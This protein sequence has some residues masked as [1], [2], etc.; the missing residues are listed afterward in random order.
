MELNNSDAGLLILEDFDYV[1]YDLINEDLNIFCDTNLEW[2][3]VPIIFSSPERSF[4]S[5][6][7]NHLRDDNGTLIFPIIS[8]SRSTIKKLK[9]RSSKYGFNIPDTP[10]FKKNSF[11]IHSEVNTEKTNL[12][13]RLSNLKKKGQLNFPQ[14]PDKVVHNMYYSKQPSTLEVVYS[15]SI[16]CNFVSQM[17]QILSTFLTRTNNINY[18]SKFRNNN[19]FEIFLN[20]DNNISNSTKELEEEERFTE[21]EF[22]I[23]IRGHIVGADDN[24]NVPSLVIRESAVDLSFGVEFSGDTVEKQYR[25]F[26]IP[27]FENR[28]NLLSID[29]VLLSQIV[30]DGRNGYIISGVFDYVNNIKRGNLVHID[31]Y[32]NVTDL[33]FN[34]KP[35]GALPRVIRSGDYIYFSKI[36][37]TNFLDFAT[38]T[39]CR[40]NISD[41]KLDQSFLPLTNGLVL[42][43]KE[44]DNFL[45]IS[46]QFTSAFSTASP[47]FFRVNKD[48]L[49]I[50][51][52]F[53]PNASSGIDD[54]VFRDS[55]IIVCG[56]FGN[57][58]SVVRR[59]IGMISKI[60][61]SLMPWDPSIEAGS[62]SAFKLYLTEDDKLYVCGKFSTVNNSGISKIRKGIARFNFNDDVNNEDNWD[63]GLDDASG[64]VLVNRFLIQKKYIYI[65]GNYNLY[66]SEPVNGLIRCS[67][68]SSLSKDSYDNGF[69]PTIN[70][71]DTKIRVQNYY[72]NGIS[73][74]ALGSFNHNG[75]IAITSLRK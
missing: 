21:V 26:I 4:L 53:T 32:G 60:D 42:Q 6:E 54:F 29:Y 59:R 64:I 22:D 38:S 61:G 65:F 74:F 63:A 73:L 1:M 8:I 58:H 62:T 2:S 68:E 27:K 11:L 72:D 45:Y 57:L 37:M 66:Q 23:L 52:S 40:I 18:I 12:R 36:G 70:S 33:D 47:Y 56:P 35:L 10:D 41:F 31:K 51:N 14:K 16:K 50:D 19:K 24:N 25:K 9:A 13:T 39:L 67:T 15:I 55:D 46:G 75:N 28:T 43:V 44:M 69:I 71:S 7:L 30:F 17:N 34:I 49:I 20:E 48:T 5:K 3:K